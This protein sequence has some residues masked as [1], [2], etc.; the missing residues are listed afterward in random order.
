[1]AEKKASIEEQLK[2]ERLLNRITHQLH[3][4]RDLDEIL[5]YLK[6]EIIALFDAERITV[7]G[8][9]T[10]KREIYSKVKEGDEVKEIRVPVGKTSVAGHTA[11]SG[12]T[13]NV[14]DVYDA[15]ELKK[16]DPKLKFDE[17][18]DQVTG[19]KTKQILSGPI[20]YNGK[21]LKGVL[22][23]VNKIGAERFSK[24]DEKYLG[25][26]CKVLGLAFN[27][28]S[29]IQRQPTKY[30]YLLSQQIISEDDLNQ[31]I[32]RAREQKADLPG[33]LV[34]DFKVPKKAL[35]KSLEA[36]YEVP[37]VSYEDKV[38]IPTELVQG[39]N[40]GYLKRNFWVPMQRENGKLVILID[41]PQNAERIKEIK[42]LLQA[43]EYEFRVALRGD[44]LRFIDT[45]L[46]EGSQGVSVSSIIGELESQRDE[47]E[48]EAEELLN[49][50]D[51][52]IV[53]LANQL[54]KDAYD[55]GASDI[56]IE[57]YF[58]KQPTEIRF[59]RDGA[60]FKYQEVPPTH[61]RPLVSR[62]K[63]MAKLD[64]AEKRL[65]QSGKI[66]LKYGQ[67]EVELRVEVTPTTGDREDIVLRILASGKPVSLEKMAFAEANLKKLIDLIE[68][69]YGILLVVGP[70]GSGKTT[71]LH[72]I[73]GQINRPEVKIWTAEDPV[74]ISQY[75]LRQVQTHAKIGYTFA[76]AMRSFLRADP[77]V[78]MVG[79][80]R[81]A[82]TASMGLEASLTGHLV[83]STLH[84]NSAPET[85]TRL[86]DM[87]MNPLNFADALLGILAQRLVR[88]ICPECKESYHPERQE[89]DLLA[90][91]YGADLF[92]E[93][94]ISY[95]DDLQL[96]RGSGCEICN[97]S[98]YRGRAAI[99]ELLVASSEIKE[100]IQNRAHME[101]IR[102]AAVNEGMRTLK[103]D[104]IL[105]VFQGM[106]D[107]TQVRRVCI[108]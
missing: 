29:R 45:A 101:E 61:S 67:R 13:F 52:G 54:I 81:D 91:E 96:Y 86:I 37:F 59:R 70:T 36:Y 77:D 8:V 32:A 66:K 16:L 19:F 30:D 71:T 55:Q 93:L 64:I 63:I 35:A 89:F 46:G 47:R 83:L 41:D 79:E 1:V 40:L 3:D 12:K 4:A 39:L 21:Y 27:N 23:V 24:E 97:D 102:R 14:A 51:A 85:V 72:S 103:Q 90:E 98:G 108:V 104:G 74:E 69:P 57:P 78:I 87:G 7:Y 15:K 17:Q 25:E 88:T 95:N 58:G 65:P 100:L 34:K 106:T 18:W 28:Q 62:V 92:E 26:I 48:E 22:E 10:E 9:D 2:K 5:L 84:T 49:E 94:N 33:I 11:V 43:D 82:E 99:H 73:L 44:I 50:S 53:R 107:F 31:A 42:A 6:N 105:K 38:I 68:N 75:G 20:L 80:M 56:H 60:C 76:E